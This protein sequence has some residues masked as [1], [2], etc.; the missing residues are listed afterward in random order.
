MIIDI[1]FAILIILA[2]IQGFRRGLIIAIFSLIAY[3]I[4][5]AAAIKLSVVVANYLGDTVKVSV[6]WLPILSFILVFV[7][8]IILVRL[9][10]KLL[11]RT[12]EAFTLGWLNRLGGII[13]YLVIYLTIYSIILFY[14]TEAKIIREKTIDASV[15]FSFIQPWGP[16]A[17]NA[18]GA[19]IPLFKDMF[20]ELESFF[21][22][23]SGKL[24][25]LN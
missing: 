16:K 3:F 2:I 22:R 15:T 9:G 10:A 6:K 21:E 5:L 23:I 1:I 19:I 20:V 14:A 4:G 11:Q 18:L 13:F 12:A 8:V 24:S 25:V 17:M 7:L